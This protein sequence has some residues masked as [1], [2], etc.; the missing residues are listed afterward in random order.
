MSDEDEKNLAFFNVDEEE[1]EDEEEEEETPIGFAIPGFVDTS[2]T[3]AAWLKA[4][5]ARLSTVS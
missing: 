5:S 4:S 3:S 2:P 1:D